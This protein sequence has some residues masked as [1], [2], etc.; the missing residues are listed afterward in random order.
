MRTPRSEGFPAQLAL[1]AIHPRLVPVQPVP[2]GFALNAEVTRDWF[3]L[4]AQRGL[5]G[6]G[7]ARALRILLDVLN[8]LNALHDT[9]TEAGAPDRKSTRLNSSH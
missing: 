5:A 7:L 1:A 4:A 3:E 2:G 9:K 6:Y 8:G